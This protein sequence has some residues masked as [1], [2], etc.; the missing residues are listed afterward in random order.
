[1]IDINSTDKLNETPL[2]KAIKHR[3]VENV[4][5]LFSKENLNYKNCYDQ[6]MS[7]IEVAKSV[8]DYDSGE[9]ETLET[10]EDYLEYLIHLMNHGSY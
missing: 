1:M 8:T 9:E 3:S 7:A 10:K 4:Q 6:E 2:V 5:L